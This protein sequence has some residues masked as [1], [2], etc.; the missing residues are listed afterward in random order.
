[1]YGLFGYIGNGCKY[2]CSGYGCWDVYI[3]Y[4]IGWYV[5]G[6]WCGLGEVWSGEPPGGL[7]TAPPTR[8]A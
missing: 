4:E 2:M 6:G 1:M 8:P 7:W 5:C 3:V